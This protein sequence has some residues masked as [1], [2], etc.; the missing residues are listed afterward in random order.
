MTD[1]KE[2]DILTLRPIAHIETDL[3]EKFARRTDFWGRD[4]A[5]VPGFADTVRKWFDLIRTEGAEA[6]LK[7]ASAEND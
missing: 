4:L 3:P 7:K 1:C 5:E 6:A 2:S